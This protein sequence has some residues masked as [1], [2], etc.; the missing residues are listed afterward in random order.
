MARATITGP[1]LVPLGSAAGASGAGTG[2][3][4][5]KSPL[6]RD[7]SSPLTGAAWR[8]S[9]SI[10]TCGFPAL[11]SDAAVESAPVVWTA[12]ADTGAAGGLGI[13]VEPLPGG[14]TVILTMNMMAKANATAASV[15]RGLRCF[16]APPPPDG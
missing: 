7:S 9:P 3:L 5:M 4:A 15:I 8:L 1:I 10:V 13:P 12:T 11:R 6:L 2:M 14:L 16:T